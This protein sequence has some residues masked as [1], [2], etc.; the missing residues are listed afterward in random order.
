MKSLLRIPLDFAGNIVV[1]SYVLRLVELLGD[2]AGGGWWGRVEGLSPDPE[3]NE[4]HSAKDGPFRLG[5]VA[6]GRHS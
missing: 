1:T 6:G 5:T 4:D 3:R 2:E